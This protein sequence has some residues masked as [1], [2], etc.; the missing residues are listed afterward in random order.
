MTLQRIF[1]SLLTR[2]VFF[3]V[4]LVV[5]GGVVRYVVLTQL[6]REDLTQVVSAQ[7]QA[8]ADA[9]AR[10]IDYK[11]ED[12]LRLLDRLAATLP[13]DLLQQPES[14]Q[15]WLAERHNLHPVFSLGL[16]IADANGKVIADV[17]PLP[18]RLGSSI[19]DNPDFKRAMTGPGG[20]GK[21]QLGPF[22]KQAILPMGFPLKNPDG[23]VRAVLIGVTALAGADFLDRILQGRIGETGSFLLVSPADKL[24]VAA[25][26]PA[27]ILKPTPAVGLDLL[28]D[29]AMDGFR[30]S[31]VTV[32]ANGVEEFA[33]I[34]AVPTTGWFVVA[35]TPTA[36]AFAPI[37]R[38]QDNVVRHSLSAIV[39]VLLFAG[40]LIRWMLSPLRHAAE[41]AE[42][43]THGEIPLQPLSVA[44]DD[45]V[46]HLTAAFNQLLAKLT[47]SQ[48]EFERMAH[49][50]SLT[51]LPN[52]ILLADRMQLGLA[53]AQRKRS[54]VAV[55]FL[56]LDGFKPINDD[57]GHEAGDAA[58]SEIARRLSVVLRQSDTL[59]RV[60]GDEFVLFVTDIEEK[61][62][63]GVGRLA[64]KC[65]E[66]VSAPL[67]LNNTVRTLGVSIGI[68]INNGAAKPEQLL[69]AA[70][71][72][73]YVAKKNGRGCYSIA[74]D[75]G[76][77]P[78]AV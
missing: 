67:L 51:G 35:R 7:Q 58:L 76:D 33:T 36:E 22:S 8:L 19:A 24:F 41:L 17:P 70:D 46:G 20:V 38:A 73:M 26:D 69:L 12:R 44:R 50:D 62:E 78:A 65:I 63:A 1:N 18:G 40:L 68:A 74:P 54:R 61:A 4:V 56:D 27:L 25:G 15:A 23:S 37:A 39:I 3:G 49:H 14:L 66:I 10:D 75:C 5:G 71:K 16:L 57:L 30:G 45:E 6:L 28:H 9:V 13:H 64:N 53:R 48:A 60:G 32:N 55:L 59:A 42:R 31:G 29:R 43:M 11:I 47:S 52:R 2:L 72:A 77:E 21:A 34:V